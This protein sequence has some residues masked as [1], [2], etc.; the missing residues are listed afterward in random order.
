M[1]VSSLVR[2]MAAFGMIAPELSR[3]VPNTSAVSN[4]AQADNPKRHKVIRK[5]E[6]LPIDFPSLVSMS[7]RELTRNEFE[8]TFSIPSDYVALCGHAGRKRI[9]AALKW[10]GVKDQELRISKLKGL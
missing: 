5:P 8:R 3:T 6:I 10:E 9:D 7:Q 1:P 4:C 2:V